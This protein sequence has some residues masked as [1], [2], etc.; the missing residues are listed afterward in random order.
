MLK[1]LDHSHLAQSYHSFPTKY[2]RVYDS[3]P[4]GAY[5]QPC[6]VYYDWVLGLQQLFFLSQNG[7]ESHSARNTLT[8]FTCT[9][10]KDVLF[11]LNLGKHFLAL[12]SLKA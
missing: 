9:L 11:N 2:E 7:G 1:N 3:K 5:S 8:D 10:D 12:N 6:S 4:L